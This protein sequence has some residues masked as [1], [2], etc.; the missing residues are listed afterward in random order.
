MD[1]FLTHFITIEIP[2]FLSDWE[3]WV[4]LG[5]TLYVVFKA[6]LVAYSRFLIEN[7]ESHVN[8]RFKALNENI[9]ERFDRQDTQLSKAVEQMTKQSE[10]QHE[11]N[12][13]IISIIEH[14]KSTDA[15]VERMFD[16][17]FFLKKRLDLTNS[18]LNTAEQA[19]IFMQM[20]NNIPVTIKNIDITKEE[21]DGMDKEV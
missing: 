21:L 6:G 20:V 15:Q 13:R 4:F 1:Q 5:G 16:S 11:V 18:R 14:N 17:L 19:I 12:E 9:E 3:F 7:D 10:Y 2:S 8:N